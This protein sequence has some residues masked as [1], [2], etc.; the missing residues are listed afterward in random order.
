MA[1]AQSCTLYATGFDSFNGPPSFEQGPFAV[2]WC[3]ANAAVSTSNFCPTGN[4]F[5]L[6]SASDDPVLLVHV[7]SAPCASVTVSFTYGQ[8]AAT[9]TVVRA[10]FTSAT[11]ADCSIA[12]PTTVG[13][14]TTTGGTCTL[15]SF[16]VELT[17]QTGVAFRFD[18][19]NN[20]NA[21]TIDSLEIAVESCC[22][23]AHGCC[24]TGL[25]GCSDDAIA[26]CVCASDP[27]CC[28]VEW[29]AQC[30]E[31]VET[32]GCG[33][34]GSGGVACL[35]AFATDF[36][37]MYATQSV[38]VLFPDLFESCEGAPPTLT[39]S[40]GCASTADPAMRFGTGFPYSAAITRCL[41][42]AAMPAPSLRFRYV[43][44][45]GTLGPRIDWRTQGSA[46]STAWQPATGEGVGTCQT[47]DLDLAAIA[48]LPEIQFRFLSGSSVANGAAFDDLELLPGEPPHDACTVGGPGCTDASI[49]ACVCGLD[50]YC[51][52]TAWD[53]ACIQAAIASCGATC[54][55]VAVCG[56]GDAGS[57]LVAHA[58]AFC[59]DAACC[60]AVCSIDPFCCDSAWDELCAGEA[61]ILCAGT[62]CGPGTGS[63]FAPRETAGCDDAACCAGVCIPDP[64]C[65]LAA[66]DAICAAE[67]AATC[68][69]PG[70][71]LDGDGHV[72][73][74]DLAILLAAW[75]ADGPADLDGSGAVDAADLAILLAAWTP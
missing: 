50:A 29:D 9:S 48:A 35:T 1:W 54:S 57:C 32:F 34:C 45:A 39:I 74:S 22:G 37:S 3:L 31:E 67:A 4:A 26:G 24:E 8:F 73:G 46:W 59:S 38:C 40:G 13:T 17:G 69:L 19:G 66:W 33:A 12:T 62:E 70:E 20:T 18:H 23:A 64:I 49:E 44:N 30:V 36:G 6:D 5:K 7:G 65:C 15:V 52:T 43:R 60:L 21:I 28:E 42:L 10:G 14:L 53:A 2:S 72:A 56:S 58:T 25:L 55:G 68:R 16:T 11:V 75:G 71:D 51:C 61:G 47:V 41:D 27:Y 63:C